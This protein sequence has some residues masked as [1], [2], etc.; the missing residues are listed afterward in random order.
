MNSII[1]IAES[2]ITDVIDNRDFE[3]INFV[4]SYGAGEYNP[5]HTAFTAVVGI[6]NI[7]RKDGYISRLYK[8]DTYGDVFSAELNIRLYGGYDTSGESLTRT[9]LDL[10]QAVISADSDGFID[11]SRISSLKYE[12]GTSAVYRDISFDIEYVLCEAMV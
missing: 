6:E 9:A 2:L 1:D 4:K 12:S 10:R 5:S 7:E 8:Y 11:K 3:N